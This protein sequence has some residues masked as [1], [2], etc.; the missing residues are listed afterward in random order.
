[1]VAKFTDAG[2]E[3]SAAW[4]ADPTQKRKIAFMALGDL[5]TEQYANPDLYDG[6]ET[7]LH[8]QKYFGP[9]QRV[10]T[11]TVNP[12]IALAE[13]VPN[14]TERGWHMREVGV[15][16]EGSTPEDDPILIWI[17]H[18]PE[19]FV[20]IDYGDMTVGEMVTVPIQFAN[21]NMIE[22]F[23][24]NAALASIDYVIDST[25][26]VLLNVLE[27]AQEIG[28]LKNKVFGG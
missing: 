5:T 22:I 2:L 11:K 14:L 1:M 13:A 19:T 17:S 18:H 26:G 27:N 21:A 15:F 28:M 12:K 25:A 3:L 4:E 7:E 9:V 23:T 8:D 16:V 6:T 24:D 10:Y 20:P